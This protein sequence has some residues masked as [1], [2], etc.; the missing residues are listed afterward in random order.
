MAHAL[1]YFFNLVF[2]NLKFKLPFKYEYIIQRNKIESYI[3]LL[4]YH[5]G[6]MGKC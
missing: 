2:L 4:W 1:V 5:A 3:I 6:D